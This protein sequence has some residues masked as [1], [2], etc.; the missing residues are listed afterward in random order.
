MTPELAYLVW[1]AVLTFVLVL[2]AVGSAAMEVGLPTLSGNRE[3]MSELTGFAGRAA[4]THRN[5]LESLILFAILVIVARLANIQNATTALGAA[6]F[7]WARVAHS[8]LYL[9]GIPGLRT[10]AWLVSVAGLAL[11]FS[12]LV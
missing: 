7:F 12:Q 3:G 5:M 2:I 4:R 1:S 11:I 8:V 9:A 10:V 6:L